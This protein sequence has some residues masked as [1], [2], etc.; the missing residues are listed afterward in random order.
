V[1]YAHTED[2]L[3]NAIG[4]LRGIAKKKIIVVFGC[5]GERDKN[6]R[7]KMGRVVS[8]LAD[9]AVI[10]SDN[11]RSEDPALIIAD[12]KKGIRKN[13][14]TVLAE[15]KEAIRKSLSLAG[16]GDIVL[17]AGKGHETCRFAAISARQFQL[18]NLGI[19]GRSCHANGSGW[20]RQ[21]PAKGHG[22]L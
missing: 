2:A 6:K 18:G 16:D 1:D 22:W 14:Y 8:E 10:T 19:Q 20:V 3:K 11:P 13:N 17:V 5:G 15:R 7:P 4:A 12:I 9:Y 21:C